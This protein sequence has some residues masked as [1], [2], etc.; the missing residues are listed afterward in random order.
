MEKD[1]QIWFAERGSSRV[2]TIDL[3]VRLPG[4][5]VLGDLMFLCLLMMFFFLSNTLVGHIS[6]VSW[7]ITMKLLDML[8]SV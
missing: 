1:H 4:T 2:R 5:V 6:E 3:F 7:P 8:G